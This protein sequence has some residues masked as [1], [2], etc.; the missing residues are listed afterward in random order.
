[1]NFSA[2]ATAYPLT[3]FVVLDAAGCLVWTGYCIGTGIIAG[4]WAHHHP[5]PAAAAAIVLSLIIGAITDHVLS[6]LHQ[7]R[8]R[9][10]GKRPT[11]PPE[12]D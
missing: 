8:T 9:K 7:T 11:H 6:H 5:L 3:R 12:P 1:M 2:G 4:K 10:D